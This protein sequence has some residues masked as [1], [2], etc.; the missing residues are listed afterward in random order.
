MVDSSLLHTFN[1]D[2]LSEENG[3]R[4]SGMF[5]TKKLTIRGVTQLGVRRSQLCGGLHYDPATPGQGLD[6][7]TYQINGM[8]AQLELSLITYPDWWDL[9]QL[10]DLDVL[11]EVYREVISFENNFRGPGSKAQESGSGASSQRSGQETETGSD[12]GGAAEP[13][14]GKQVQAT[15]EP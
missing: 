14:V 11:S 13:V 3:R 15:L 8:I 5:T 4:Y 12:G 2:F 7:S 9:D 10:T 6:A 1:V